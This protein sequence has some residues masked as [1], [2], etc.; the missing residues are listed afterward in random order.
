[1]ST[2]YFL[3][4]YLASTRLISIKMLSFWLRSALSLKQP[5]Q[6][7]TAIR[8]FSRTSISL[9][10]PKNDDHL[11]SKTSDEVRRE[12]K[13]LANKCYKEAQNLRM[14]EDADYAA[15]VKEMR[16]LTKEKRRKLERENPE[17]LTRRYDGK[18][19][20][21]QT[22]S[23]RKRQE[24]PAGSQRIQPPET[25]RSVSPAPYEDV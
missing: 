14:E 25:E 7:F 21:K 18:R 3:F 2:T 12:K 8:L 10:L 5:L 1:M 13:R 23:R 19:S 15:K 16:E 20:A 17:D 11:S 24:T 9:V 22:V 4:T 6:N